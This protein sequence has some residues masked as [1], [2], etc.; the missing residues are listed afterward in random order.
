V[1]TSTVHHDGSESVKSTQPQAIL[2]EVDEIAT[3]TAA[4]DLVL[5]AVVV[6]V[7]TLPHLAPIVEP[8]P[9]AAIVDCTLDPGWSMF[10]APADP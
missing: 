5:L 10:V 7:D 8:L 3:A 6:V 4:A 1:S 9:P 2:P